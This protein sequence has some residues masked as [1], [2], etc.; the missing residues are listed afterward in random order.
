MAREILVALS[1]PVSRDREDEF[2][3]RYVRFLATW[4]CGGMAVVFYV[5]LTCSTM[6]FPGIGDNVRSPL[7]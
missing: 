2:N 4:L 3:H 6:L 5:L 7:P 1:N